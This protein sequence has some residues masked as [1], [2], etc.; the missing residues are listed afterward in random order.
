MNLK[1]LSKKCVHTLLYKKCFTNY[2]NYQNLDSRV[3]L[4]V[5][6]IHL[7]FKFKLIHTQETTTTMFYQQCDPET[8]LLKK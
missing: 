1:L 3:V 7:K 8:Y 4:Q 6:I 2:L 5:R